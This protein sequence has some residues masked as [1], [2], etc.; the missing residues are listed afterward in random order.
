V[1][2]DVDAAPAPIVKVLR[3]RILERIVRTDIDIETA[4]VVREY[5]LE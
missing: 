2:F 1:G 4:R 3:D 5:A